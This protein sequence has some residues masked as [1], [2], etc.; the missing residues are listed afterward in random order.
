MLLADA[1]PPRVRFAWSRRG[2]GYGYADPKLE[3]M[4]AAQK[5]LLRMGPEN[6]RAVQAKLREIAL[7]LGIPPRAPAPLDEPLTG[8]GNS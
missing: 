7:A 8:C 1:G 4:P 3:A 5:Q 6:A 2:I